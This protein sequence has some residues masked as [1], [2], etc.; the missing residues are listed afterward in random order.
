MSFAKT[1][2]LA[3]FIFAL[4]GKCKSSVGMGLEISPSP[5]KSNDFTL[6]V[7]STVSFTWW[8]VPDFIPSE[9]PVSLVLV[10]ST[11]ETDFASG[12]RFVAYLG[13]G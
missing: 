6:A 8:D 2:F 5:S 3:S 1:L 11:D 9:W 7:N 13:S 12:A 4:G 10:D